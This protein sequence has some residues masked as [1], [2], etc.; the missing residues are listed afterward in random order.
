MT[1][2]L[3]QTR[4]ATDSDGRIY[5]TLVEYAIDTLCGQTDFPRFLHF[6]VNRVFREYL[7]SLGNNPDTEY[8]PVPIYC[9]EGI[10]VYFDEHCYNYM[11]NTWYG[12]VPH[13]GF[14][15]TGNKVCSVGICLPKSYRIP[16][17]S[18]GP[19]PEIAADMP[20][21]TF[22]LACLL[23]CRQIALYRLE[24][25]FHLASKQGGA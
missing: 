22:T 7:Y 24:K 10:G 21:L 19:V 25:R 14:R 17:M 9:D 15:I 11:D 8:L 2:E 20:D 4:Y 18:S 5:D 13:V 3:P 6:A 1:F 16:A 12:C 23:L